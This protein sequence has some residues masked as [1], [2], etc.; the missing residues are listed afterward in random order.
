M[1][2]CDRRKDLCRKRACLRS[3]IH[4]GERVASD[5]GEAADEIDVQRSAESSRAR[6]IEHIVFGIG[7]CSAQVDGERAGR[8]LGVASA[9]VEVPSPF[10][11]VTRSQCSS[12]E[13]QVASQRSSVAK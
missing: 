13:I 6:N 1:I 8:T 2:P 11:S 4:D 7:Y 9:D 5:R 10:E 3:V 12:G